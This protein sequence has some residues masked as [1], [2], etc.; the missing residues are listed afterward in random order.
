MVSVHAAVPSKIDIPPHHFSSPAGGPLSYPT[1]IADNPMSAAPNPTP[2][3]TLNPATHH[4]YS[5]KMRDLSTA[6]EAYKATMEIMFCHMAD[7]FEVVVDILAEKYG[8]SKEEMIATVKTHPAFD[9]LRTHPVIDGLSY[10]TEAEMPVA[11]VA[12][13]AGAGAG[14]SVVAE[15]PATAAAAPVPKKKPTIRKK[16][17]V[18]TTVTDA[19][20]EKNE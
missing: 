1:R 4:P 13:V 12:A 5:L 17:A 11:A 14:A 15:V 19:V 16:K 7:M 3:P 9:T 10:I 8:H 18:A 2:N 20:V 6:S